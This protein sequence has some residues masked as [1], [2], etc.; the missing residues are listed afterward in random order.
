MTEPQFWFGEAVTAHWF[1]E[2]NNREMRDSGVIVGI[3]HQVP[4]FLVEGW[5]YAIKF[6]EIDSCHWLPAGHVDWAHESDLRL[7]EQPRS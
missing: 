3:C 1:N 4:E 7:V 2:E 5:W 6:H